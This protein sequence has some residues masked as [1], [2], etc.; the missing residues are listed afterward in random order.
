MAE[1]LGESQAWQPA[2]GEYRQALM[3]RPD[4][5]RAWFGLATA[6]DT[7]GDVQGAIAAYREFLSAWPNQD[8]RARDAQARISALVGG[9]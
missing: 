2:V 1:L 7:I 5:S 4:Y 8:Q 3:V 9:P 6:L